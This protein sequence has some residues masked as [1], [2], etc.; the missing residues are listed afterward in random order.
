MSEPR[1]LRT[2]E[3]ELRAPRAAGVAGLVFAALF[4]ASLLLLRNHPASGSSAA[5]IADWYLR[6]DV[7]N[8]A[9]VGLYLAPFSG[10][11]F[12][13]FIAVIRHWIGELED[14]FFS[15]VFLGSGLLFVAMLF[16]SA[17]AA[18]ALLAGVRFRGQPVPTPDSVVLSR[19][20]A[21][22][23]LYVYAMRAAAVFMLVVS[24]IGLRTGSLHRWLVLGGYA[25]ALALLF[26]P[27]HLEWIVLLF[28]AWV[29]VVSVHILRAGPARATA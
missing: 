3:R 1:A 9:L 27:T 5:Q 28:P 22:A 19:S 26:I 23:F 13:W 7:R 8:V 4:V 12:L 15:T 25:V 18:G 24:T 16:V 10:I 21:Y 2:V 6:R 11:A 20:L 29:A 14:R 17:G